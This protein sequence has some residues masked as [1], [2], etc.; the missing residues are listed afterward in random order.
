MTKAGA[1]QGVET[2]GTEYGG[3]VKKTAGVREALLNP[4]KLRTKGINGPPK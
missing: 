3:S 4:A 1:R 2:T